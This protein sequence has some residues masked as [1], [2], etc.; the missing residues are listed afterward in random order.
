MRGRIVQTGSAAELAAEPASVFVADFTGAVVLTGTAERAPGG[1]TRV[2]LDGGGEVTSPSR[3]PAPWRSPS[4]RGTSRSRRPA[5]S[6]RAPRATTS[7]SWSCRVT[8]VGG[9]VRVG[10][11]APQPLTAELTDPAVRALALEPGS[12]VVATWKA[13]ATRLLPLT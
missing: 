11:A 7:T 4:T 5:R 3:R 13:T 6:S 2:R 12:R 8:A 1:L 10:L 9:R